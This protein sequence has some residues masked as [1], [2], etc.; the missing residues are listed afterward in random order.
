MSTGQLVASLLG[1]A[2]GVF[3]SEVILSWWMR[4]R[5]LREKALETRAP[6]PDSWVA[7]PVVRTIPIVG[8]FYQMK[9]EGPYLHYAEVTELFERR[10]Y[11]MVRY[12]IWRDDQLPPRKEAIRMPSMMT[13]ELFGHVYTKRV[14]SKGTPYAESL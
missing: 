5:A 14:T 9:G 12:E 6:S 7:S 10:G 2:L 8:A 3:V 11:S 13:V 4:R 1:A